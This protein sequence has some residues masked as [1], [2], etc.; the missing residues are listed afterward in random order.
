V[1]AHR[2]ARSVRPAL[3]GR[4]VLSGAAVLG[5][6]AGPLVGIA[7]AAPG[8]VDY[9]CSDFTYQ[10]DA[11]AKLLPGDPY[12]LDADHDGVACQNL[13]HRGSSGS[14]T[15]PVTSPTK[16]AAP[17]TQ[18]AGTQHSGT[19]TRGTSPS[20]RTTR[21]AITD[22]DCRDFSSQAQAQQVLDRD[23]S[24]PNRLDA[25]HDGVACESY[26][27]AHGSTTGSVQPVAN[28]ADTST[29]SPSDAAG[30]TAAAPVDTTAADVPVGAV[31][32]GDGST[33]GDDALWYGLLG[34]AAVAGA[35]GAH[36]FVGGR[37]RR[38]A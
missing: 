11:Q 24:D 9:N 3:A 8:A 36:Q 19:A 28:T 29:G 26:D 12:R 21:P 33:G 25:D 37:R 27:Y 31:A 5:L 15:R 23:H 6:G 13:P 22:L 38:R 35:A 2:R 7:S 30:T 4:V 10:E 32:A 17:A 34:T 18:Q 1:S 20:T 16:P 14:T